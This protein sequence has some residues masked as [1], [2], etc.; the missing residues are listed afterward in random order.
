MPSADLTWTEANSPVN[1]I[2]EYRIF[3]AI[4][5]VGEDPGEFSLLATLPVLQNDEFP[6]EDTHPLSFSDTAVDFLNNTY[7]YRVDAVSVLVGEATGGSPQTGVGPSNILTLEV[8]DEQEMVLVENNAASPNAA[9]STTGIVWTVNAT[10]FPFRLDDVAWSTSLGLYVAVGDNVLVTSP[11][12]IVWTSQSVSSV[13]WQTVYF[14]DGLDLFIG[15]ADETGTASIMSSTDAITWVDRTT[16]NNYRC[17][18]L[19]EHP[20][21]NSGSPRILAV[22]LNGFTNPAG[23]MLFSNNGTTWGVTTTNPSNRVV[24]CAYDS[25]LD[26][27]VVIET[28]GE[29]NVSSDCDTFS[30]DINSADI[31]SGN[32]ANE[33]ALAYSE[34]LDQLVFVSGNG[35]FSSE[36]GGASWTLRDSNDCQDV[37]YSEARG[38]WIAINDASPRLLTSTDGMSWTIQTDPAGTTD[39]WSAIALGDPQ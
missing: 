32:V 21:A 23:N 22:G 39:T 24:A 25:A 14:S 13:D 33:S 36:D 2:D 3:K 35:I 34:L 29:C 11:D 9:I 4:D 10:L 18:D 12:G 28:G 37:K 5:E 15:G 27:V 16:P 1:R 7:R 26:R 30:L 8:F 38:L 20:T 17:H 19:V 6:F 31:P